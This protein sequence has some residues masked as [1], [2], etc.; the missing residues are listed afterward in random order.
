[1]R[2]DPWGF[3]AR[4]KP[5]NLANPGLV[6]KRMR[7]CRTMTITTENTEA[8]V[9]DRASALNLSG[10]RKRYV[11][12]GEFLHLDEFLPQGV[13]DL[14][15]AEL[16]ALKP[17][18][19][20]NFVPK[21]KKGGSVPFTRIQE[22]APDVGAVYHSPALISLLRRIVDAPLK[23]CPDSDPHRCALYAYTEEGDHIGFHYD[24]SYYKDRRWTVLI[25]LK[26]ESSS[27]LLCHLHTKTPGRSVEKL[28]VQ[29]K[30]GALV[31]FNGDTVYHAVSPTK[32]GE[33]RYIV[34]M[35]Y[36][37]TGEMNP[38]LRLF[39]NLKD[40]FAYFG[41][42]QVFFGSKTRR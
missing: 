36:V 6:A 42:K 24:T 18:I 16:E 19:H 40:A 21:H 7:V 26:D 34:T 9:A 37:T 13:I 31:L 1:M 23:P 29:I 38:F 41:L 30:P 8:L 39:S 27:R 22:L 2:R 15:V 28:E 10:L 32:A 20:R 11:D 3:R 35:Q 25:G 14:W 4:A 5:E 12:Q 33:E 17:H